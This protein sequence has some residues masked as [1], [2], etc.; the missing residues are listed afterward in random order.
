MT[1]VIDVSSG[2]AYKT[3]HRDV[4]NYYSCKFFVFIIFFFIGLIFF[5]VYVVFYVVNH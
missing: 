5:F 3:M 4:P 2:Q 1:I